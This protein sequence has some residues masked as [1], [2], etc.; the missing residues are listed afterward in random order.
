MVRSATSTFELAMIIGRKSAIKIASKP[1]RGS[2]TRA[3]WKALR[4]G[5]VASLHRSEGGEG[6]VGMT[7]PGG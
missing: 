3:S 4:S 7:P 2:L 1:V 5:S 6:S